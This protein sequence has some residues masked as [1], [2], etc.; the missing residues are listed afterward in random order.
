MGSAS[1]LGKKYNAGTAWSSLDTDQSAYEKSY[2]PNTLSAFGQLAIPSYS[3]YRT[4]GPRQSPAYEQNTLGNVFGRYRNTKNQLESN[5]LTFDI[6]NETIGLLQGIKNLPSN[7]Y[8]NAL[9]GK[10]LNTF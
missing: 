8:G 3:E 10:Y 4:S 7:L 1:S 2:L 6:A 9:A 5:P